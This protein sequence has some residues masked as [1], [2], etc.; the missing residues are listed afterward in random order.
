MSRSTSLRAG[1]VSRNKWHLRTFSSDHVLYSDARF[2]W[3][4]L[5]GLV[6]LALDREHGTATCMSGH[7]SEDNVASQ[8]RMPHLNQLLQKWSHEFETLHAAF[9]VQHTMWY[10]DACASQ[11]FACARLFQCKLKKSATDPRFTHGRCPWLQEHHAN[12]GPGHHANWGP[13]QDITS[14]PLSKPIGH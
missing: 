7:L 9:I 8:E 2:P 1:R 11:C 13:G 12:C 5:A 10:C 6:C 3:R 4:L 14:L